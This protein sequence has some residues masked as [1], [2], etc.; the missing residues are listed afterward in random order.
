MPGYKVADETI[1]EVGQVHPRFAVALAVLNKA[2][3]LK[4]WAQI[5]SFPARLEALE[6]VNW[7]KPHTETKVFFREYSKRR[8]EGAK[9]IVIEFNLSKIDETRAIIKGNIIEGFPDDPAATHLEIELAG[10]K[11]AHWNVY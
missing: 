4:N 7:L 6:V 11:V 1:L 8:V 5:S 10:A 3:G 2:G 9:L